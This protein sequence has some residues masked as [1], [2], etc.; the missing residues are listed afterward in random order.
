M[1]ASS[2]AGQRNRL[3]SEVLG[4]YLLVLIGPGSIIVVSLLGL[5]VHEA[6]VLVAA[7]FGGTVG[8]VILLLGRLSGAHINPAITLGSTLSG[9]F[10]G[11]L[12]L[13]YVVSQVAGGLLA[14]FSLRMALGA[15]GPV[16]SLGSTELAAGVTPLYGTALE[17]VGTFILTLSALLA[18]SFVRPR[19][20][21]ALLVGGTLFILILCIGPMTGASFNP[22]RSLGPS[23]VSGYFQNQLVYYVGPLAGA[24]SAGL[25][26]RLLRE[27]L[28]RKPR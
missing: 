19:L 23:V 6:L 4:T 10:S 14:A 13:P 20:K 25:T 11:R 8:G 18:S 28:D 7:S 24:A 9:S 26:F 2:L 16:A 3:F 1:L 22:A 5:P 12:L 17:F 15:L 27:S 21:Q